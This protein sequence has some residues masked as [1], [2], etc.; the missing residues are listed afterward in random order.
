MTDYEKLGAFYLGK[1][2]DMAAGALADDLVLY[3]SKDL[4]THAVIIGMTGSGKT[5]LG[6]DI[7]EEAAIDRIPVIAIDPKGDLGNLLLAFPDLKGTDLEPWVNRTEAEHAGL[8]PADF[9]A[10][11]AEFWRKGMAEWDQGV[12]RIA[13][14][15]EAAEFAIYTPGS[16]AG[17]PIAVLR[18]FAVPPEAIRTDADLFRERVQTTATSVLALLGME[19]D[20]LTSRE[21]ILLANVLQ[22]AWTAGTDLDLARLIAQVQDPPFETIG[23]MGLEQVFPKKDRFGFAMQLNNLLAAPGFEAWMQGVPLDASRLLFTESGKPRVSVLSI[24]HLGD[25]ERMFFVTMLLNDLIG[26]M[27]QQPGTGTLRAILYMDEIAGYLPPVANPASKPLFLTLLKQ[28]RAFGLGVVLSTQNPADLDYKALSNAGTWFLGRLQ[29]ERDKARVMEG[30]E[31]VSQGAT[32]DRNAMEQLIAG[33]GKRT[34][35][36][37]SVHESRPEVFQ[38]RW[39]M[40]YLA[41]PLTREQIRKLSP[42]AGASGAPAGKPASAAHAAEPPVTDPA[43]GPPAVPPGVPQYHLPATDADVV[44]VPGVLGVADVAYT[45]AK[46]GVDQSERVVHLAPFLEGPVAVDWGEAD[47]LDIGAEQV[48]EGAPAAGRFARVPTAVTAKGLAEW[49]KSYARWLRTNQALVLYRSAALRVLSTPGESERDFRVRLQQEAREQRDARV[50]A[51][52]EKYAPKVQA[53]QL[54]LEQARARIAKEQ[55]EASADK[56]QT[57]VSMGSAIVGA[58]FGRS[59][60]SSTNISRMGTAARG[61]GRMQK[62]AGDVARAEG[63]AE[64]VEA[65]LAALE[66]EIEAEIGRVDSGFDAQQEPLETVTVK[67]K[68]GALQVHAVGLAWMPWRET[69]TGRQPAWSAPSM[70]S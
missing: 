15:R 48:A 62:S 35:L 6:I 16:T 56:L 43:A 70:P 4:T 17:T 58:L 9:A 21:H 12:E 33:L 49:H 22:R 69:P 36:L 38:T 66:Q 68:A 32:F 47:A 42:A 37:H 54:K 13:K 50:A 3:D 20:P 59:R 39:T 64:Q 1:R 25:Q 63:G 14:L 55:G 23:V 5:G 51:L 29:A 44:W 31:G 30:L 34:F 26:W 67:P 7:I 65:R 2:Y 46:L 61:V 27:R 41:G 11:Q 8:S 19:A 53:L 24:A 57:A 40:S 52:R 45:N 10:Q 28:A 60:L 18:S